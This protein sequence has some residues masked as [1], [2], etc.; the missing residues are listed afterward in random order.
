MTRPV[1]ALVLAGTRP[2]PDP[3]LAGTGLSSKALFQVGGRPMLAHVLEA[4][5]ESSR[6]GSIIVIA[7]DT[8]DLRKD[9]ALSAW[10]A[11]VEW[12]DSS[13]SIADAVEFQLRRVDAPLFVTTAD[14]VLLT[15]DM[16]AQFLDGAAG[17][18]VAAGL[19]ERRL[20]EAAGFSSARTWLKFRGGNW[21][22]ANVFR[23]S[24]RKALPLVSFWRSLEQDRK[25]GMKIVGAM[26]P[27]LLLAAILR[28]IDIHSFAARIG[29]RFSLSAKVVPMQ[30]AEAC[31]DADK[32]ADIPVIEAILKDRAARAD[33]SSPAAISRNTK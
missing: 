28:L 25:K 26:G 20:V 29:R 31:I 4:L 1:T 15:A 8:R 11:S 12:R 18:D 7:Q 33:H 16:I 6:V 3:L 22:G 21:S 32:P 2:G 9:T 24:G 5:T 30:A 23:L 19:V 14:N 10:A 13:G 27:A 17:N